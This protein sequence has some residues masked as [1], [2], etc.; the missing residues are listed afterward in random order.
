M[1]LE[2]RVA[3]VT[4]AAR[5]VGRAIALRLA[6]EG[7]R[8]AVHYHRSAQAAQQTAAE[9]SRRGPES[10]P[11]AADLAD[12]EAPRALVSAVTGH[13]GRLDL[14]INNAAVFERQSLEELE[15]DHW[16]RTLRTNLTAPLLLAQA[17]G[18]ALR[19]VGGRIVN[20]CDAA[21]DRPWPDYLAYAVSKGALETLT[22]ALA[23]T[24]APEVNVFGIAPGIA[25]WPED[26]DQQTRRRL[27]QRVPLG[28]AGK[29][30]EVADL[31]VA[32]LRQADYLT[33]AIVPL[34]GGRH[35][36]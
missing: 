29:P 18:E 12:L 8:V 23:R 34:D 35:L 4:G 36:V 20:L 11:V 30:E 22:R 31:L 9:C 27:L 2:G 14:L 17:A 7:C 3:L 5:R 19:A 15:A 28:R 24:F 21:S 26:Y 10:W 33:G 1:E 13:F 32:L 16:E 25:A 6:Q